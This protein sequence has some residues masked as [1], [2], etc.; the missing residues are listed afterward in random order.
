MIYR[1]YLSFSLFAL[2]FLVSCSVNEPDSLSTNTVHG[3]ISA[4]FDQKDTRTSLDTSEGAYSS[5]SWV[6]GD[7]ISVFVKSGQGGGSKFTTA[8]GGSV[9]TFEGDIESGSTKFNAVYPYSPDV[10]F[11]GNNRYTATLPSAQQAFDGCF[12][13]SSYISVGATTGGDPSQL[14]MSF[15]NVCGGIRFTVEAS[16][17]T[18]VVISGNSG[19]SLAGTLSINASDP[20]QPVAAVASQDASSVTLSSEGTFTPGAFYYIT[21]PPT[22]FLKGFSFEFYKG[23]TL[24]TSTSTSA[25]VSIKRAVYSTI[26]KAD[27]QSTMDKIKG[28]IDLSAGGTANCYV[29]SKSGQYMFPAVKGN[30]SNSVGTISS[31]CVLWETDNSSSAV[32]EGAIIESVGFKNNNIYFRTPDNL[33]SGNA[34]I[35]AMNDSGNILWSWH[36]WVCDGYDPI[37]S[38]QRYKGKTEYWMD[39]N[40]G[41]LS[42]ERGSALSY[43]LLYQWGRKDPFVGYSSI[44]SK[45]EIATTGE[46]RIVETDAEVGTVD[47][48]IKNPT[49]FISSSTTES[50]DWHFTG[51]DNTLWGES[52]TMYDPCPPGWKVPLG[53]VDGAWDGL[54]K[55]GC[56]AADQIAHGAVITLSGSGN[57]W[58]PAPGYIN[59]SGILTMNGQYGMYCSSKTN[60]QFTSILEIYL[61]NGSPASVNDIC[62]GKVR[63]EGRSLRCVAE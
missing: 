55:S 9:A 60:S 20:S 1:L 27:L 48:T 8:E 10:T 41:A 24:Y 39:R 56:I 42:A 54:K 40:V 43:G 12:D 2:L 17:I 34:L 3:Y 59:I 61:V 18:S 23:S 16:G 47:Y 63:A 6:A 28:G 11:D 52:K 15:Y 58:Y 57:A 5:I 46:F 25:Y 37:A 49:T 50:N 53:G 22:D 31:V 51:R 45:D 32:S 35:A 4:S 33:R 14:K 26:R 29:V 19:E 21:L 13:P 36:I 62:S 30:S 38:M 44:S 7:F